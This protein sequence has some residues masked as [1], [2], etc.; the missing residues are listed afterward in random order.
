MTESQFERSLPTATYRVQLT[1]GSDGNPPLKFEDVQ[2]LTPYLKKMGISHVYLSP[3]ME[4]DAGSAGYGVYDY[5]HIN[6]KLG[7]EAA[8]NKMADAL[9][10]AGIGVIVDI[11]PNHMNATTA[12]PW[13]RDV[14][15]Y[16]KASEHADKFD[17]RWDEAQ[18]NINIPLLGDNRT[19]LIFHKDP[20]K[21]ELHLEY[22]EATQDIDVV[23]YENRFPIDPETLKSHKVPNETDQDFVKRIN[24]CDG[25]HDLLNLLR[26]QHYNIDQ[27]QEGYD[28]LNYRRFFNINGLIGIRQ[29]EQAVFDASHEKL[30]ELM[31]SGKIDGV[32][33][34][35]IDGVKYP[36]DYLR[37]LDTL[38]KQNIGEE[39]RKDFYVVA[40]KILAP[41]EQLPESWMKDGLLHG[42]TG[43]DYLIAAGKLLT[44]DKKAELETAYKEFLGEDEAPSP[45]AIIR[46]SR[47]QVMNVELQPEYRRI[48]TEMK[49]LA[50]QIDPAVNETNLLHAFK[51]LMAIYPIY[52]FYPRDGQYS[53]TESGVLTETFA[54]LPSHAK[55]CETEIKLLEKMIRM[56]VLPEQK[57]AAIRFV[58][59][60]QQF[61]SPM[62][63]KGTEDTAFYRY[64]LLR[65]ANEVGGE[66]G[67]ISMTPE[68]FIDFMN[69]RG[70]Q[71]MNVS[72]THDT[73]LGENARLRNLALSYIPEKWGE[74]AKTW[75]EHLSETGANVNPNDQYLILQTIVSTYP[76]TLLFPET[77]QQQ[78]VD[79]A[80]E[81]ENYIGRLQQFAE[82]ALREG[83]EST[84]YVPPKS[85]PIYEAGV[86]EFIRQVVQDDAFLTAP[87]LADGQSPLQFMQRL[88]Q[89]SANVSLQNTMLK[90][91][92]PGI[93]DIY[94]GGEQ[95]LNTTVDPDNR[96]TPDFNKLQKSLQSAESQGIETLTQNWP[97]GH[98][99]QLVTAKL[100]NLRKDNPDIFRD[101]DLVKLNVYEG[102]VKTDNA[103]AFARIDKKD[104]SRAAVV[105]IPRIMEEDLYKN[106]GLGLG[107]KY[108]NKD[109]NIELPPALRD[110]SFVDALRGEAAKKNGDRLKFTDKMRSLPGAIWTAKLEQH[111]E[112]NAEL[113]R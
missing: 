68:Q 1:P 71:A 98:I 67:H 26:D 79:L 49:S 2:H 108:T 89:V 21:R 14:L 73:K 96:G 94:Q 56:D 39:Q 53:E 55:G 9:H 11:V 88:A 82:K 46:A 44:D 6:E 74:L 5:N 106:K 77:A 34:D 57:D 93:P 33:I 103:L 51:E 42:T 7:G 45:E 24:E 58:D 69:E 25:G 37:K 100:L 20:G 47:L 95:W 19:G 28:S 75:K 111:P 80:A 29:E 76:L 38:I 72:S 3:I 84:D 50:K 59:N 66:L 65:G 110:A 86:R 8:F 41:G 78:G 104:P 91:G 10:K 99:K 64:H 31:A 101:G 81:K 97:D 23:Y 15:K 54:K 22:N 105:F 36:E 102:D 109:V 90:I 12:N 48:A 52:R 35:H 4:A 83:K 32:R 112:A 61:T 40:E 60:L 27:W 17:I 18:D 87:T 16:G 70:S 43:Y 62:V 30:G 85:S 92:A 107:N 13:F 63:A 113:R